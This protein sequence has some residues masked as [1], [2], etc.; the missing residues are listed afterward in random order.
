MR[1]RWVALYLAFDAALLVALP[2]IGHEQAGRVGILLLA[3]MVFVQPL[4][5]YA[6]GSYWALLLPAVPAFAALPAGTPDGS[7]MSLAT[8]LMLLGIFQCVLLV[9]GIVA[10]QVREATLYDERSSDA[11]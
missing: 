8:W 4:F 1:W 11:A 7:E 9:P 6:V 5:G 3:V 10:R 2:S